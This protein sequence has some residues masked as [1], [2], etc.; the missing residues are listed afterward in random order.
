MRRQPGRSTK[1][2]RAAR[3][4]AE[5]MRI[6]ADAS[7][8]R[9]TTVGIG[10]YQDGL[11]RAVGSQL[12]SDDSLTVYFNSSGGVRQ[13]DPPVVERFMRLPN[14]T[15]WNQIRVP[16]ELRGGTDVYLAAGIVGPVLTRVPIVEIVLDCLAF[17]HP[18]SKTQRDG[19]YWR[20]WTKATASR[21]RAVIAI[22]Q[23]VASDCE[24]FLGVRPADIS[25]VYPGV[26]STFFEAHDRHASA[27]A[28]STRFSVRSPYVLQVGAYDAHKGGAVAVEAVRELRRSGRDVVLVQCGERP[29]ANGER[30]AGVVSLGHVDDRALLDLYRGAAAVCVASNHE[31]FGLPVV[32][33]MACGTPVIASR[34]AALPEAGGDVARY[35]SPGDVRGL[36]VALT[37]VL[38]EG[39]DAAARRRDAGVA[40]A[41]RFSWERAAAQVLEVLRR[42]GSSGRA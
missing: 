11:L 35:V 16:L 23:F 5:G 34:A 3:R 24:R 21:A 27:A 15:L 25:V 1:W 2:L 13:F 31:G 6:A 41:A 40:W 8:T 4:R 14:R 7:W 20:R 26:S 38:D 42:A 37:A 29:A 22:S 36:S 33:A 32:E 17:R 28:V 39:P 10:R 12:G 19:R 9:W 18:A 30:V